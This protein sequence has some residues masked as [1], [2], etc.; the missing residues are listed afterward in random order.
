[1]YFKRILK[2]VFQQKGI[3]AA[4]IVCAF[5]VSVLMAANIS[6]M[7]PVMDMML[8]DHGLH[9]KID[10]EVLAARSGITVKVVE[11]KVLLDGSLAPFTPLEVTAYTPVE[12]DTSYKESEEYEEGDENTFDVAFG[13]RIISV[14]ETKPNESVAPE[15]QNPVDAVQILANM[16]PYQPVWLY[17]SHGDDTSEVVEIKL[18]KKKY[19]EPSTYKQ[20]VVS[21]IPRGY[22]VDYKYKCIAACIWAVLIVAVIRC[23]LRFTQEYL[24]KKIS[25]TTIQ[26]LRND[27]FTRAIRMPLSFY[28]NEGVSDTISRFIQDTNRVNRGISVLFGKAV[29]EPLKVVMLF[30]AAYGI[31]P[32]ITLVTACAAPIILVVMGKIGKKSKK[33]TTRTLKRWSILLGK[34]QEAF[35]GI[36]V[37]KGYH[38]EDWE[39]QRFIS[40]NQNLLKKQLKKARVEA[41]SSPTVEA[42]AFTGGCVG[43]FFALRLLEGSEMEIAQFTTLIMLLAAG[44]ESGRKLGDVIPAIQE[45]NASAE[46]VY[47]LFDKEIE[48]DA[49]DAIDI[50]PVK[51]SIEFRDVCF[52]YPGSPEP[53]LENINLE[54]KAGQT[55][56]VVG[57][58][59][60]GKTTLLSMIP[61]FFSL[62]SGQILIDGVD[63]TKATLSSLRNQ[64]GIVTQNTVVFN[65]TIANNIAY[66]MPDMSLDRIKQAAQHAYAEDFINAKA[67]GYNEMIGEQGST[68]SGGQLQRLAIA[69]AILRDPAILI[70]DE[71]TSQIDSDSEAKIQKALKEFSV[72]RTSFIIAHRLSTILDAD[73]IVV[74]ERGHIV[75]TGTHCELLEKSPLYKQLYQMQFGSAQ[76]ENESEKEKE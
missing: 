10:S 31:Q 75:A 7:L 60:S 12:L 18:N 19:D 15:I 29:R 52:T 61:R 8:K 36:K 49:T 28:T 55:I 35:F 16:P 40:V 30:A 38:R 46:R 69:R 72:G 43:M 2:Y 34:L 67:E 57:P 59:G 23:L 26:N 32:K 73:M 37:V 74:M 76:P 45:A 71:A 6:L 53:N 1:M 9:G 63:I 44:G 25:L 24:V 47:E 65:D 3:L 64:L 27:T 4:S 22:G 51:E 42:L 5:L 62:E 21:H 17:V 20:M 50:P 56:A 39:T 13:D 33:A 14:W 54:V 58:N 41:S 70:F 48:Q 66:G 68:L 11:P